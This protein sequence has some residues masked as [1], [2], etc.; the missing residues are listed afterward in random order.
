MFNTA[1][2]IVMAVVLALR[3]A[4]TNRIVSYNAVNLA[5]AFS[6]VC[7]GLL[8]NLFLNFIFQYSIEPCSVHL[9]PV[10]RTREPYHLKSMCGGDNP[11]DTALA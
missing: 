2:A 9:C 6:G 3:L 4:H 7:I 1:Y 8:G 11:C 10:T 5:F